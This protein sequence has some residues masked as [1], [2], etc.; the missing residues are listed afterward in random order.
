MNV[1]RRARLERGEK[2]REEVAVLAMM[3]EDNMATGWD[4][5]HEREGERAGGGRGRGGL[6]R[7]EGV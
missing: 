2:G 7:G 5:E 6:E 3:M 1:E 4:A